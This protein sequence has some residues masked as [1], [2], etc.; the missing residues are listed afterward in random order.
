MCLV[1]RRAVLQPINFSFWD[2]G[3]LLMCE[4]AMNETN[5]I[6][7]QLFKISRQTF[8]RLPTF[9]QPEINNDYRIKYKWKFNHDKC[10]DNI[11]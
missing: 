4:M 7:C 2:A 6:Q 10:R 11:Q 1:R 3:R 8:M 9:Q 5:G